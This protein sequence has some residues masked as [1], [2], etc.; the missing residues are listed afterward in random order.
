MGPHAPGRPVTPREV[1]QVFFKK[2]FGGIARIRFK[3][4]ETVTARIIDVDKDT[5]EGRDFIYA[6]LETS[7][8]GR[9]PTEEARRALLGAAFSDVE[10]V[11]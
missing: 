2:I 1:E 5:E 3:S 11:S 4:G 6:V 10:E 8:P 9:Y 7:E